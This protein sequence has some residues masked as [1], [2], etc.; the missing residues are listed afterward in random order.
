MVVISTATTDVSLDSGPPRKRMRAAWP[1]P[2]QSGYQVKQYAD[3]PVFAS[4]DACEFPLSP[5]ELQG[6]RVLLAQERRCHELAD[7]RAFA[8]ETKV[9]IN[10]AELAERIYRSRRHR[11][12]IFKDDIFADP[13]WDILLDL[14]VKT[15]HGEQVNISSACH[16]AGVPEATALRYLKAL[17]EKEYVERILHDSDRRSTILRL[18]D[19]GTDLMKQWLEKFVLDR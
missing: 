14:F 5:A 11:E 17:T 12:Q 16:A 6:L 2:D 19:L 18:T 13:A 15:Q 7:V 4:Q 1:V 9:Q 8:G 10:H 3:H